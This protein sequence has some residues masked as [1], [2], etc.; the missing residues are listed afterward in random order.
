[1]VA[2][3]VVLAAV[4]YIM[5]MNFDPPT[6]IPAGTWGPPELIDSTTV[7][8]DYG[9]VDPVPKPMELKINLVR[10]GTTEGTYG[11]VSNEEGYLIFVSGTDIC[12]IEYLDLADNKLVNRGD[13][14]K[15]TNLAPSSHY[16]LK[17]I[18]NPTGDKITETA[19]TT[20]AA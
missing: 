16:A 9:L 8:V 14:I 4:L 10:N 13:M 15:M 11:Y 6:R 1:M 2:I 19:F 7:R 17:M 18:W 5:V 3:T 12:D 20:T